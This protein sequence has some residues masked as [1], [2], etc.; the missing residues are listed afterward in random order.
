MSPVMIYIRT[1]TIIIAFQVCQSPVLVLYQ[2]KNLINLIFQGYQSLVSG[3]YLDQN[4]NL[5]LLGYQ[6]PILVYTR[7]K[8]LLI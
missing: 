8:I 4:I 5:M 2:D 1:K 3:L 6:P 7:T